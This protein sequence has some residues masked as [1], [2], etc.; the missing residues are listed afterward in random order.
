MMDDKYITENVRHAFNNEPYKFTDVSIT[1][2][3]GVVEL[4]GFTIVQDQKNRAQQLTE[5]VNGVRQVVN[6]IIVRPPMQPTG[7]TN[8]QAIYSNLPDQHAAPA[9]NN[10]Q[11]LNTQ[12]K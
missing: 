11:A 5:N 6:G 4:T 7:P 3:A 8:S 9:Q 1:T 10:A 2:Y 12:S